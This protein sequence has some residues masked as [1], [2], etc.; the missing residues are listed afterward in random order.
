MCHL[1]PRLCIEMKPL[2][3]SFSVDNEIMMM[4]QQNHNFSLLRWC[5]TVLSRNWSIWHGD[6]DTNKILLTV[7]S[8]SQGRG[9]CILSCG[10]GDLLETLDQSGAGAICYISQ[11]VIKLIEFWYRILRWHDTNGKWK[12]GH[13]HQMKESRSVEEIMYFLVLFRLDWCWRC[14]LLPGR[15]LR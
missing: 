8:S 4:L 1:P 15:T 14:W 3:I 6:T 12:L 11:D 9:W 13:H 2:L 5:Q 7:W 10:C